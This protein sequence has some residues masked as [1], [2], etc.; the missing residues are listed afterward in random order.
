MSEDRE[1]TMSSRVVVEVRDDELSGSSML[2]DVVVNDE[3]IE[4]KWLGTEKVEN[5]KCCAHCTLR[6]T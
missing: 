1:Q 5:A 3:G 6:V 4:W 2:M